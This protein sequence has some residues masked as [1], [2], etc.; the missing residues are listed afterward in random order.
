MSMETRSEPERLDLGEARIDISGPVVAGSRVTCRYTYTAGHPIDDT[1]YVKIAFRYAGDF[2]TPQFEEPAGPEYC[3]VH[4]TGDCRVLPRWDIKGNTRPWG[5]CLYLMVRAGFLDRGDQIAVTFGDRSLGSPGWRVQ[6]F[7]EDTFEFKTLVDP[8]AT[9]EFKEL[10]LSPTLR[11]VPGVAVKATCI[12]PSRAAVGQDVETVLKLDDAWGN[13]VGEPIRQLNPPF[14]DRGAHTVTMTDEASG[15]GAESNPIEVSESLSTTRRAWADFHG[16]SE[17]TIGSNTIRDYYRFARDR[18][19]VDV[20]AHQGNDFQVTDEFWET[21][22]KVA[23]EFNE[24]G[25]FVTFPGYEWSG[26]TP[27]GGD[28]NVYFG[29]GRGNIVHSCADLLPGKVSAYGIAA[30]ADELFGLLGQQSACAPFAFAH[31]GGRYADMAMHDEAI[32]LAVEVHSAW[33][34]FEWLVEDALE[35]GY[36]IGICANSDG[37]KGR[38]GASY[39]GASRFGSL[40]GLTCLLTPDLTRSA[41]LATL[42][43]RRFYATTGHRP[44]LDVSVTTSAGREAVMGEVVSETGDTVSLRC[45]VVGTAAVEAIQVRN[46]LDTIMEIRNGEVE[47]DSRRIKIVWSG[48]EVRGRAR[49]VDWSGGLTLQDNA[50]RS[51]EAINFWNPENVIAQSDSHT[52]SWSSIT[53]GGCAGCIMTVDDA[54]AGTIELRSAQLAVNLDL[55]TFGPAKRSWDCGGLHKRIDIFRLPEC[56]ASRTMD[57]EVD[58][59]HLK[60]GDNP[61]YVCVV[62][63][64][65][66][67]AW[68]SPIY[69]V[70]D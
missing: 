27:L 19:C 58:I 3:S 20:S 15:L 37:H 23:D 26:N 45:S 55:A 5:K 30:T 38:P 53:T 28:R 10:A 66:H 29:S 25:R 52:A 65:G 42:R 62:Q 8:I 33:G 17:E 22:V 41:V 12:A 49:M 61:L 36:R 47:A 39:P 46:G 21:I 18:A 43:A 67:M 44:L 1:G 57:I 63:E 54:L 2:G 24:D 31:V 56:P 68:S 60:Q 13:P 35:R 50:I 9:F 32:E 4:T 40:G 6:T 51:L 16:Q 70:R 69:V 59:E 64:D 11:I 48:A 7:C 34:T 14:I